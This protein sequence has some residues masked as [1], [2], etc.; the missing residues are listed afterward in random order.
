MSSP[1]QLARAPNLHL[2]T[3]LLTTSWLWKRSVSGM[4][5]CTSRT[6]VLPF[7]FSSMSRFTWE[8]QTE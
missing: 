8:C 7:S 2:S 4:P 5:V 1:P 3:P 6:T